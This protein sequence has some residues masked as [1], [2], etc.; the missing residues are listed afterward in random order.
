MFYT[1]KTLHLYISLEEITGKKTQKLDVFMATTIFSLP[2]VEDGSIFKY[3]VPDNLWLFFKTTR[4]IARR[5][6]RLE[7]KREA[8]IY[9][10]LPNSDKYPQITEE[11]LKYSWER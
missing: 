9:K 2:I 8:E 10:R 4:C 5:I 3:K 11:N 1:I 7:N 6:A